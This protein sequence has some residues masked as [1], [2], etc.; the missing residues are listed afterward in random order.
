MRSHQEI[1][2]ALAVALC[3]AFEASSS[4]PKAKQRAE[5]V[6]QGSL[7]ESYIQGL[8]SAQWPGRCQVKASKLLCLYGCHLGTI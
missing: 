8:Q 5:L 7:P 3:S 1:N 4:A 2:A 6:G